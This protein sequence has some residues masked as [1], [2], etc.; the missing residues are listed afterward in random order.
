MLGTARERRWR[1]AGTAGDYDT[2]RRWR[3]RAQAPSSRCGSGPRARQRSAD[4][5]R[6]AGGKRHPTSPAD[7]L[8]RW[9]SSSCVGCRFFSARRDNGTT[10]S[11]ARQ[12]PSPVAVPSASDA[13]RVPHALQGRAAGADNRECAH[14]NGTNTGTLERREHHRGHSMKTVALIS[15]KGGSGKTTVAAHV[16]AAAA[17]QGRNVALIDTDPQ[18]SAARWGDR[19]A[20]ALPVVL[21]V[22]PSRLAAEL[23]RCSDAGTDL[24]I[25]DTPPRAGSDNAAQVAARVADLVLLPCRPSVLDME[26]AADTAARV[27]AVTAA[28]VVAVLNGCAPRGQDADQV[29]AALAGVDV[30]VA[31]VRIGQRIVLARSLLAGQ[32]AQEAEPDGRAAQEVAA[33]LA[34]IACTLER[35]EHSN[36]SR[37]AA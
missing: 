33:V 23:Q 8:L 15:M 17:A 35:R 18:Q 27:R 11:T 29:A 14:S 3:H 30:Q 25:I 5:S 16:A 31:P 7:N 28:P 12:N 34:F 21:T 22:P 13:R 10:R 32:V 6:R 26:A 1:R 37:G 36:T 20:A 9:R 2:G 4:V 24:A 19:R